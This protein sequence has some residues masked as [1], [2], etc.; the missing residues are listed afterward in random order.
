MASSLIRAFSLRI[1][2]E[3]NT[4]V[5]HVKRRIEEIFGQDLKPTTDFKTCIG[6]DLERVYYVS[7]IIEIPSTITD[8]S[9]YQAS[10]NALYDGELVMPSPGGND[11]IAE[12]DPR[13]LQPTRILSLL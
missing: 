8:P 6:L 11:W 4:T 3:Q 10:I 9:L 1:T 13:K 12:L 7:V 2:V 5:D